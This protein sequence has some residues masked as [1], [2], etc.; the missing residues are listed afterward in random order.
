MPA[1]TS[2][3]VTHAVS[4]VLTDPLGVVVDLVADHEPGLDR[5]V[6]AEVVKDVSGGRAKRRRLAQAL[7]EKP[8]LLADGCSP[9]PRVVGDLLIALRNAGAVNI[10]PPVCAECG[11]RLRTLQRRGQDWYCGVCGLRPEPCTACGLIRAVAFRGRDGGP[12]CFQCPP[13]EPGDPTVVV[14]EI[15]AALDP[16]LSAEVV[17]TATNA[18][19]PQPG[20]R[21]QLAWAL[22]DR[23]EL[24]TGAGA[25]A[26]VPS[27]LRLIE[28][29]CE[30]GAESIVRPPCPHCGRVIMLVKPR[31]G[32]R[33][34][35]NC[36]A[37]SRAEP[38][39]RCGAVREAAA[40]DEHG[41]VLCPGCLITDPSN[42]EI[43]I[44]CGR[45]RP[46]S[47]RT[48]D[49]PI[50]PAC[51]PWKDMACSIC[52]KTGPCQ[53]S[54]TT[55]KPWCLTCTRRWARCVGCGEQG[56]VRGGTLGEPLCAT[57]TRPEP[58]FWRS[59]L[60]CGQ[61]GRIHA[62]RCAR[63]TVQQRLRDLLGDDHGQI[64][65]ELQTLYQSL[66]TTDRT[67]TVAA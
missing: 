18:A 37:K 6:I 32:L 20:Q 44:G 16:S 52:E 57:C 23:P 45:R 5:A 14:A 13:C 24:L 27:V 36:V 8:T 2:T 60:G 47:V 43:C 12:R 67:S 50:C 64:R 42:L 53:I 21:R 46:V 17:L 7:L 31:D 34:C 33:L 30:A 66:A 11:K 22:T 56:Q 10:S 51:R 26:P 29:L 4:E 28:R 54:Q 65:P 35:R 38:C 39:S 25:E 15:V 9:A 41:G 19:A 48:P 63:C 40:R 62:G 58:G 1:T 49:G 61:P 3:T 59:C 55:G